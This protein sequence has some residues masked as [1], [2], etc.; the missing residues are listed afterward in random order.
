MIENQLS[1][2]FDRFKIN[3][4]TLAT[5]PNQQILV[6]HKELDQF[7]K[8]ARL[9]KQ[10]GYTSSIPLTGEE[11]FKL[12]VLPR[13]PL[14]AWKFQNAEKKQIIVQI[15]HEENI[16]G[17]LMN[18]PTKLISLK[19]PEELLQTFKMNAKKKGHR[20]QTLIKQ[21]MLEWLQKSSIE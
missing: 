17:E 6:L 11:V 10:I 2:Y 3:A 19:V 8:F 9:M 20:Y 14:K 5:E 4:Q 15:A 18:S 7:V 16:D 12:A 1:L 13:S 21:L